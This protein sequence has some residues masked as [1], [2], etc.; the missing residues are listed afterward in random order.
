MVD[1]IGFEKI[2]QLNLLMFLLINLWFYRLHH[3][4][5]ASLIELF[6]FAGNFPFCNGMIMPLDIDWSQ[7]LPMEI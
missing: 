2:T 6:I 7:L 4:F 3:R 5:C 1:P